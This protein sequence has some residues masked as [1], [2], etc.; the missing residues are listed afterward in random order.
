MMLV[1]AGVS[2]RVNPD[3]T[4]MVTRQNATCSPDLDDEA[5]LQQLTKKRAQPMLRVTEEPVKPIKAK[6][7]AAEP[8]LAVHAEKSLKS[9]PHICFDV[10]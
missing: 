4:V 2:P 7:I 3:L 9:F 8:G 10:I 6:V 1:L 5:L